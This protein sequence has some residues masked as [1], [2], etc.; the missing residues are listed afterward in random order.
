MRGHSAM[1]TLAGSSQRSSRKFCDGLSRRS[2]IH[3]GGL[4]FGGLTLGGLTL[5]GLLRAEQQQG[6]RGSHKAV[7]LVY[8]SGGMAH[9]DT[10]DLK[11]EAPDEIRGEFKPIDTNLSGVQV[12]ELLPKLAT[13]M[14]KLA[15]I[16]SVVGQR[17]EHSSF[18]NLTGFPMNE[19]LRDQ[20]PNFGCVV[21]RV[22]GPTHPTVPPYIDLFPTMKHRPYN[23]AGPGFLGP[24]YAP[25]KADGE[26]LASMK[27]RFVSPQE[28]QSRRALLASFDRLRRE[29]DGV[30]VAKMDHAYQSAFEVLTSGRLVQALD[31]EREDP[32][33]RARYGHGS[34]VHQGDGA[35]LWNEQ[36]LM[37]R[38]L[39]EAGVRVVTVGF[40]FWDTHSGNFKHLR[41]NLPQF[42]TAVAALVSDLHDR[43]LDRDVTVAV[44]GEFGRTPKIN[45]NAGRDHWAPVNSCLLAGGGL[46][47]G[48]V[49]G[50]TD[51]QAGSVVS[52]PVHYQDILATLYHSLGLDPHQ[53][54]RDLAERPVPI[55]PSTARV[56]RELV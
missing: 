20:K 19:A 22:Q 48:Q 27:L 12:C 37:A 49:I 15:V 40:G 8:P 18:Q 41:G 38:R 31:I 32:K 24:Q 46:R 34:T 16:R 51:K 14:D 43:G 29:A 5:P 30:E 4:T 52:R 47:V 13:M 54:I 53:T 23:S 35:P 39:V 17:D 3:L 42:D 7:I 6:I 44:W 28:F 11:P 45:K 33:V 1:L 21:G 26:D 10:F 55:L 2:F 25:I 50:R 36:L 56:I 9:Q